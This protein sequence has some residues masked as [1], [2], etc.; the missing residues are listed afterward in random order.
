MRIVRC[1]VT[2]APDPDKVMTPDDELYRRS[3]LARSRNY[4]LGYALRDQEWVLWMDVDIVWVRA[5][6]TLTLNPC[7]AL[8]LSKPQPASKLP[9]CATVR[10]RLLLDGGTAAIRMGVLGIA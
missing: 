4:L 7:H 2:Q 9:G 8:T 5:H 3:I 6:Q 10:L 1:F